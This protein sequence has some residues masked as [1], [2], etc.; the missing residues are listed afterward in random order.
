MPSIRIE[1]LVGA[2]T[3]RIMLIVVV[4]PAPFGPSRPTIS[5]R[6]TSNEMPSTAVVPPYC[7]VTFST[8]R[9]LVTTL[10]AFGF[11]GGFGSFPPA[12]HVHVHSEL[13]ERAHHS[14]VD[15][16]V[17]GLWVV[18]EGGN[19]RHDDDA[20]SRKLQHVFQV[21][22]AERSLADEQHEFAAFLEN[23]VSSTM[24]QVIAVTLRNRCERPHTA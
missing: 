18:V 14:V 4:L 1:P 23:Y 5:F 20:H 10:C 2:R 24:D 13:I 3:P 15:D 19:G 6:A 17:E 9:T 12:G 16:V 11:L 7:F 8:A 22:V 21:N